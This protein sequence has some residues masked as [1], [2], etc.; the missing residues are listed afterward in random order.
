[1]TMVK[2]VV[3]VK[4][5]RFGDLI[6]RSVKNKGQNDPRFRLRQLYEDKYVLQ[7]NS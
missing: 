6:C 5:T 1:M 3:K 7:S 4:P 2:V